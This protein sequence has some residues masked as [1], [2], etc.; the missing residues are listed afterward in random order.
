MI[1]QLLNTYFQTHQELATIG[2]FTS[3][4]WKY[5]FKETVYNVKERL[6]ELKQIEETNDINKF[7][8]SHENSEE[9]YL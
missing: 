3:F 8:G 4:L 5:N 7:T 1:Y 2:W 6:K 9:T